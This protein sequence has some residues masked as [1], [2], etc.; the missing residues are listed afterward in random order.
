MGR[1][2]KVLSVFLIFSF[3]ANQSIFAYDVEYSIQ[4]Y[5]PSQGGVSAEQAESSYTRLKDFIATKN[6]VEKRE[7]SVGDPEPEKSP[8]KID[9]SV[10]DTVSRGNWTVLSNGSIVTNWGDQH[11]EYE[12]DFG[13]TV[14]AVMVLS[15]KNA[16]NI[17]GSYKY[18]ECRIYVD[19]EDRGKMNISAS[20]DIFNTGDFLLT[21]ISGKHNVKIVWT[22]DY[23]VKG[24]YDANINIDL[25]SFK[26][27]RCKHE[28]CYDPDGYL[29]K[30]VREDGSYDVYAYYLNRQVRNVKSYS[31]DGKLIYTDEYS[32]SERNLKKTYITMNGKRKLVYQWLETGKTRTYSSGDV[33]NYGPDGTICRIQYANGNYAVYSPDGNFKLYYISLSPAKPDAV[34]IYDSDSRIISRD[35]YSYNKSGVMIRRVHFDLDG[36]VSYYAG[37]D[38][39]EKTLYTG[40]TYK[41][42]VY[43][44]SL[45]KNTTLFSADNEVVF[46]EDYEYYYNSRSR[47]YTCTGKVKTDSQGIQSFYDSAERLYK[48]VYP[49][50]G[51]ALYDVTGSYVKYSINGSGKVSGM[52]SFSPENALLWICRFEYDGSGRLEN[53]LYFPP[54][55]STYVYCGQYIPGR[56]NSSNL[57]LKYIDPRGAFELYTW[58]AADE[59]ETRVV[60]DPR[61][62]LCYSEKYERDPGKRYTAI[63]DG[64][65]RYVMP[66]YG[67]ERTYPDG[68]VEYFDTEDK[69]T[70]RIYPGGNYVEYTSS[71][72]YKVFTFTES[73]THKK[74]ESYNGA[75]RL[76][77]CE[78]YIYDKAGDY[79][80][81]EKI[82]SLP[83]G[84]TTYFVYNEVFREDRILKVIFY[85]GGYELYT[86]NDSGQIDVKQM[87][88]RDEKLKWTEKYKYSGTGKKVQIYQEGK[89]SYIYRR[90]YSGKERVDS[91]GTISYFDAGEKLTKTVFADGVYTLYAREMVN[92]RYVD[93]VK[94]Y[95]SK[96]QL[97]KYAE[98]NGKYEQYTYD[99]YGRK[100]ETGYFAEDGSLLFRDILTYVS[101]TNYK[102]MRQILEKERIYPDGHMEFYDK[103]DSLL[104]YVHNDGSYETYSYGGGMVLSVKEFFSR[105]SGHIYRE[106]YSYDRNGRIDGW[107]RIYDSGLTEYFKPDALLTKRLNI[108]GSRE[109]YIYDDHRKLEFIDCFSK[110]NRLLKRIDGDHT[111]AQYFYYDDNGRLSGLK[112]LMNEDPAGNID[113]MINGQV[114][115]VIDMVL[116]K[117]YQAESD[118]LPD[119]YWKNVLDFINDLRYLM[120]T[121]GSSTSRY[122]YSCA[123]RYASDLY[124]HSSKL[125]EFRAKLESTINVLERMWAFQRMDVYDID[126]IIADITS[127]SSVSNIAYTQNLTYADN[128]LRIA[129]Q[130]TTDHDKRAAESLNERFHV[131]LNP[132]TLI[133]GHA[134]E[135]TEKA[136]RSRDIIMSCSESRVLDADM[137]LSSFRDSLIKDIRNAVEGIS[138]RLYLRLEFS[139]N[140]LA[141]SKCEAAREAISDF[142]TKGIKHFEELFGQFFLRL[143][144]YILSGDIGA[145]NDK[146]AEDLMSLRDQVEAYL[147]PEI[148][149]LSRAIYGNYNRPYLNDGIRKDL[150]VS[151]ARA[152]DI[153]DIV[154]A[155]LDRLPQLLD[156]S[157]GATAYDFL[158]IV[159]T[160]PET[161]S[162]LTSAEQLIKTYIGIVGENLETLDR[163]TRYNSAYQTDLLRGFSSF[164]D[165][166]SDLAAEFGKIDWIIDTAESL[167]LFD[168]AD[169]KLYAEELLGA[170]FQVKQSITD[171]VIK[172]IYEVTGYWRKGSGALESPASK[173]FLGELSSVLKELA[174]GIDGA[175]DQ[176]TAR[177]TKDIIEVIVYSSEDFL[178]A[179]GGNGSAAGLEITGDMAI[180]MGKTPQDALNAVMDVKDTLIR[181]INEI[182]ENTR[183]N[184]YLVHSGDYPESREDELDEIRD[185]FKRA[186][187]SWDY[188]INEIFA[189]P[190]G[191][192]ESL[193]IGLSDDSNL[194][195]VEQAFLNM[196]DDLV[197]E[198]KKDIP[199]RDL[200]LLR[201]RNDPSDPLERA[202]YE[203]KE[204]NE[205][206]FYST[207]ALYEAFADWKAGYEILPAA[208]RAGTI[209]LPLV[210]ELK[211]AASGL[212]MT[213]HT[214][215][216]SVSLMRQ[217]LSAD[218][219]DS[220]KGQIK[221][222]S[223]TQGLKILEE[224]LQPLFN[225]FRWCAEK[226]Q[227][228]WH[229]SIPEQLGLVKSIENALIELKKELPV[230]VNTIFSMVS[231]GLSYAGRESEDARSKKLAN[232]IVGVLNQLRSALEERVHVFIEETVTRLHQFCGIF[233]SEIY[234]PFGSG[235]VSGISGRI[236]EDFQ[237][238]VLAPMKSIVNSFRGCLE[239]VE[240]EEKDD[241]ERE[242]ERIKQEKEE[243]RQMIE[244]KR[245]ELL[246]KM[247]AELK[248]ELS[249]AST[250]MEDNV[251]TDQERWEL[252]RLH[253]KMVTFSRDMG[254]DGQYTGVTDNLKKIID[255]SFEYRDIM[256]DPA[257][258]EMLKNKNVPEEQYVAA[259]Y[260]ITKNM[261]G[262]TQNVQPFDMEQFL[263][264]NSAYYFLN[265]IMSATG[266][267]LKTDKASPAAADG[268]ENSGLWAQIKSF[269]G[270]AV[271][272]VNTVIDIFRPYEIP[273]LTTDAIPADL[274]MITAAPKELSFTDRI[275]E[276]YKMQ[277]E[278]Y[279]SSITALAR[280]AVFTF[281]QVTG[282]NTLLEA[283]RGR[284]IV[285]GEYL[286][287]RDRIVGGI[288]SLAGPLH[289]VLEAM[290]NGQVSRTEEYY[291][292]NGRTGEAATGAVFFTI[293]DLVGMNNIIE[294]GTGL[295]AA[296][297][298]KLNAGER[299]FRGT[300]A[301]IDLALLFFTGTKPSSIAD[302]LIKPGSGVTPLSDDIFRNFA[303]LEDEFAED[304][305]GKIF[306]NIG[307][308]GI[309]RI[310]GMRPRNYQYAGKVFELSGDLA[311]KYPNGVRFTLDAFPDL[312]PYAKLTFKSKDLTGVHYMDEAMANRWFKMDQTPEGYVWH[313]V[314]DAETMFLI[315][316]DLHDAIPHT[317]GSAVLKFLNALIAPFYD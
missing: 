2:R 17:P 47:Q 120:N 146:I 184:L 104:K 209:G 22:N 196:N 289:G 292:S 160:G 246:E 302:D 285:T 241:I 15:A 144:L 48:I 277:K 85:S 197:M 284:D 79:I 35:E 272:A 65:A 304:I 26:E 114:Y 247:Q 192:L 282:G 25:L 299:L 141:F 238:S 61:G 131:L 158:N 305:G 50:G 143:R 170:L 291:V 74:I 240:R 103:A 255:I 77:S 309:A 110:D 28:M 270:Q 297:G 30:E 232:T 123:Y 6:A 264:E 152:M 303:K 249:E 1:C 92:G 118:L 198:F 188:R 271:L 174:S 23:F 275:F 220:E 68:I 9:V 230:A 157:A 276:Y 7:V 76:L 235:G 113:I 147:I 64:M 248:Q 224:S 183:S 106:I 180:C 137:A 19:G 201:K 296:S 73:G 101:S 51:Y 71:G 233:G 60:Y 210:Y 250:F 83:L 204:I 156:L 263:Y 306:Y 12:I 8:V 112:T 3:F 217:Y 159:S 194:A 288:S 93:V 116:L 102:Y 179:E 32:Y 109:E 259:N 150:R 130:Y 273:E 94:D 178:N 14:N 173:V 46:K 171:A 212:N 163:S 190:V 90:D 149:S 162:R 56:N 315:P 260:G 88:S 300:F 58:Y 166:E 314:E 200:D 16:G 252:I 239:Q 172:R 294:A 187:G 251:V 218:L 193:E 283:W 213:V 265:S 148:E 215:L 165:L 191:L 287:T 55:G 216:Q 89:R 84:D 91:V 122:Y 257:A 95:N 279:E 202:Y 129:T 107:T 155:Y 182:F 312:S 145:C 78:E 256:N 45:L 10:A 72:E 189:V 69:L 128:Y 29:L 242:K 140:Y 20:K 205:L 274:W 227:D 208:P 81:K 207:K 222:A 43:S 311:S 52:E 254:L 117:L 75:G 136:Q 100:K 281:S 31:L 316:K 99:E 127:F 96:D 237:S 211:R 153:R 132:V 98:D 154:D 181:R 111:R 199:Y 42:Y 138:N 105:G 226:L 185:Y 49:N 175:I 307:D 59:M 40:G 243:I 308:D 203:L 80:Y 206:F 298:E 261:C 97:I 229:V 13:K 39:L 54:D 253:N 267:V 63:V 231:G 219:S 18:F 108:D 245:N 124:G 86:Y 161:F 142:S 11:L 310:G 228:I 82:Q 186:S 115:G 286:S 36:T 24:Q 87:F 290:I 234:D 268:G 135:L 221:L 133:S 134:D 53:T 4:P 5:S 214:G 126:E 67:K 164:S 66:Y 223:G 266:T 21:D 169:R 301:G 236:M 258:I 44:G 167:Y 125:C 177:L 121:A 176:D 317:G 33:Y 269:F 278:V 34:E 313:H 27:Y 119:N 280:T 262:Y 37:N 295:D 225:G 293:A 41:T 139:D 151:G 70:K 38:V 62:K 168:T 195:M 244:K 57:L